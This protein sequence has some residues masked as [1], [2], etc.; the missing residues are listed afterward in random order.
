MTQS[1]FSDL[2]VIDCASFIAGPCAA[3]IMSDFGARVIKIEPPGLGDP[4]RNLFRLRGTPDDVDYFWAVDSRNKESLAVDLKRPEARAALETLIKKADVFITNFPFPVRERLKLRA[5]D[6]LPHNRRLIY[7]S[8]TPYG[9]HGPERDRTGYDASAW[10]ARSGMM[11]LVRPTADAEQSFSLP[12][13]GD[14]P[15]AMGMY[16]AILTALYR[17]QQTGE[18]GVAMTSLMANGLWANACQVQAALCGYEMMGRPA[19]G[20]RGTMNEAYQTLDGRS[21]IIVST[22]PARDWISLCNGV[23]RDEWL[24]DPRFADPMQRFANS[25]ILVAALD[26]IFGAETWETWRARLDAAG[27]TTGIVGLVTDHVSDPQIEANG[28]F[29]ETTDGFGLRVVD[30]PFYISGVEKVPPRMAPAI[31]QHTR[32]LLE[33]AGLCAA[34]IEA[35]AAA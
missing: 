26:E 27:L 8:L 19:R 11:D 21:F 15:T 1:L 2:L 20:A 14:H 32:V 3:T 12:G 7:A 30:S 10:W 17:R 9:E 33:E 29:P 16:A 4:Y 5:E 24:T 34:D 25:P 23:K 18:G 13:M 35:L 22:N 28:F 31:G 6:V